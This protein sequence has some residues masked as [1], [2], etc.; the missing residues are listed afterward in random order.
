MRIRL[1][2]ELTYPNAV[3]PHDEEAIKTKLSAVM[4]ELAREGGFTAREP[5][6]LAGLEVGDVMVGCSV[7]PDIL[8]REAEPA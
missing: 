8:T 7:V 3:H 5:G 4:L 1:V 6:E 2:V